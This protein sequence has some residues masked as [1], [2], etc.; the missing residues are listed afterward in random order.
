MM[1]RLAALGLSHEANSF[2][3]T[4]VSL[5]AMIAAGIHRGDELRAE[6]AGANT[7]MAGYLAAE[8]L[9]G[10]EVVPLLHTPDSAA[11]P[12]SAEAFAALAGELTAALEE[13]GPF[14]GVLAALHGAAVAEGCLDVD[15]Y[16]LG[17]FREIVGSRVPIGVA[18]D[19]H[20]NISAEMVRNASVLST[21]RTNPHVDAK[22]RAEE[23]AALVVRAARGEITPT[24]AFEPVPAVINI[25]CQ[26]T[27]EA[28]MREIMADLDRLLGEPGVLSAAVAEGYPYADVPEMGMSVVVVTDADAAGARRHAVALAEKVWARR[29][30]FGCDAATPTAAIRGAAAAVRT[31]VLLLDVGDNIGGGAPGD[32]VEL[33]A[34]ARSAGLSSLVTTVV[35]PD[36][37]EACRAAGVG[38]SLTVAL[39]APPGVEAVATVLVL[40]RGIYADDGP[41]HAG[42]RRFDSGPTAA[43]RLDT[44][45]TVVLCSQAQAAVSPA[46]LTS[47][48]LDL[49]SFQAVVAKGVHSPIAGYG[50]LVAET[51]R[52][53]TGGITRADVKSFEYKF[54][55]RPLYPFEADA[56]YPAG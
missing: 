12:I 4:P 27:D 22:E 51:I 17:R 32:S 24:P 2:E 37:V 28:P 36:A 41:T 39:G 21:Y 16:L 10:V 35:D 40:D 23:V 30:Q 5:E 54:R 47:L 34:A 13:N 43:V 38:A 42:I 33:L 50:P 20:A 25:L 9:A 15:G 19:L 49:A 48:G 52:V 3:P 29:A 56:A 6:H 55:R 18:L 11:G 44:G 8:K 1:V 31:P 53:N 46:Q 45:Q 14:D 26:G 7:T